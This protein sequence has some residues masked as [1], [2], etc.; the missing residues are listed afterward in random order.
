MD[1]AMLEKTIRDTVNEKMPGLDLSDFHFYAGEA[2]GL[3][4]IYVYE[5]R[6]KYY[7]VTM[8][9]GQTKERLELESEE[10]VLWNVLNAVLFNIASFYASKNTAKGTD[11]RRAL[12]AKEIELYSKFG[13]KFEE[14]RRKEIEGILKEHPYNDL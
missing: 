11:F 8:E 7:F 10:E 1:T 12:F 2:T 14:R 6:G 4:G 5:D 9:R 3:E 13:E